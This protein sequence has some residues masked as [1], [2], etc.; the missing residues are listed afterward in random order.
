ME[1]RVFNQRLFH[2]VKILAARPEDSGTYVCTARSG[3]GA[4]ETKV[5][6]IVEG[7]PRVSVPEP[8][9]VV[10]EGR[11]AT[12]RCIAHG[13]NEAFHQT[14]MIQGQ[15][16]QI[17]SPSKLLPG[18]PA[19]VITWSK[20]RSPMPW[21]HKVVNNSLVLP[22]VG[23]QD[24]GDYICRAS[25]GLGA[26]QATI[27]LDVESERW[28]VEGWGVR[29]A[30]RSPSLTFRLGRIKPVRKQMNNLRLL[31][32]FA[33]SS[34]PLRHLAARW[35]GCPGRGGHPAAVS[36][37]RNSAPELHVEQAGRKPALQGRG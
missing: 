5:E 37:P 9:T 26:S 34:A 3:D 28:D 27:K 11:T 8:Q 7:K 24:S 2:P 31:L 25:N 36:G 22:N 13:K 1:I 21:R 29:T 16:G 33:L 17:C 10:V 15:K 6:V 30:L 12:L 35:R 4:T 14:Q 32:D 19:P 18:F 23:R 20:L